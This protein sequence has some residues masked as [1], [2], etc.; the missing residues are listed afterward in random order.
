MKVDEID[1]R[2]LACH[3]AY[4]DAIDQGDLDSALAMHAEM[5]DLLDQ[6]IHLPLQRAGEA[7]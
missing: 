7:Y 6:R 4:L 1:R 5:D 2:L 3:A